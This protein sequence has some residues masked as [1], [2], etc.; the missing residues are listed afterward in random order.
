MFFGLGGVLLVSLAPGFEF[1]AS[2][3]ITLFHHAQQGCLLMA[4]GVAIL[5]NE[6]LL[7]PSMWMRTV[8]TLPLRITQHH[9]TSHNTDNWGVSQLSNKDYMAAPSAFKYQLI[10]FYNGITYMR[11]ISPCLSCFSTHA[12]AE[13]A[14]I[15]PLYP[16][17]TTP[18]P[19]QCHWQSSTLLSQLECLC[20][21]HCPHVP[22]SNLVNV[23][24][25]PCRCD[26]LLGTPP[27]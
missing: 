15:P 8:S 25:T 10:N 9:C 11:G 3:S 19:P 12:I 20:F 24:K 4:N 22:L 5:N 23:T 18:I 26:M 13:Y 7:E 14:H 2:H 1:A 17:H 27:R 21:D 6:R 16:G